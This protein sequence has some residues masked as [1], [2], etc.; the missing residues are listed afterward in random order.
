MLDVLHRKTITRRDN[1]KRFSAGPLQCPIA[2]TRGLQH[3]VKLVKRRVDMYARVNE[4]LSRRRRRDLAD[5]TMRCELSRV[6]E[7]VASP[8]VFTQRSIK[9]GYYQR[10]VKSTR[11]GYS[12]QSSSV[13]AVR[14]YQLQQLLDIAQ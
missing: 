6:G 13:A 12:R 5:R 9:C 2:M 4:W 1:T 14:T 7:S 10:N 8:Y 11:H 3:R